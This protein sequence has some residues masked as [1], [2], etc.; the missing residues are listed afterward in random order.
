[1]AVLLSDGSDCQ[2]GIGLYGKQDHRVSSLQRCSAAVA[3]AVSPRFSRNR[4]LS[5][6]P[7]D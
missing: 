7:E 4:T 1:M 6:E 5:V 3:W 2:R